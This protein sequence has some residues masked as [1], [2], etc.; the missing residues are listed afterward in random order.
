MS[1]KITNNE[2]TE[3]SPTIFITKSA[4]GDDLKNELWGGAVGT[5]SKV[6]ENNKL[7]ELICLLNEN[8]PEPVG[9][10]QLNDYLWFEFD[11]IFGELEI[12]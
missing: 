1:K 9:I 6:V 10:T 3:K 12:N 2:N 8:F 5:Y 7:D 4:T 11:F